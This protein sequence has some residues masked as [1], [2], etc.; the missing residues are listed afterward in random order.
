MVERRDVELEGVGTI[1]VR[2]LSRAELTRLNRESMVNGEVDAD[3]LER[4]MLQTTL[5]DPALT[6]EQVDRLFD[7]WGLP[8]LLR[9]MN[10]ILDLSGLQDDFVKQTLVNFR[11]G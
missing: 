9:V 11:T 4:K 2:G 1:T 7:A 10:E 5:V 8:T 6:A 3:I